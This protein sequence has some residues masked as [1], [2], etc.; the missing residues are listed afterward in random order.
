VLAVL[1]LHVSAMGGCS[2]VDLPAAQPSHRRLL[3]DTNLA[4][5]PEA[6]I[7]VPVA[8][9]A[10]VPSEGSGSFPAS[11]S[12]RGGHHPTP[13]E[14][15]PP[16]AAGSSPHRPSKWLTSMRWLYLTVLP[17]AGLLL[18]AGIACWLLPC[19]KSAVATIGPWKTGLSGQLQKAFVTGVP[20]LQRSELERAC[21][22]FS[23]IIT[24]YPHYT[25]Y[26]GT[27]S[28]GVE[29]AV[30]STMITSSK[31][32]S[33]HSESCFRKKVIGV[34]AH[35]MNIFFVLCTAYQRGNFTFLS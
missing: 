5:R 35:Y 3:Q 9:A 12:P 14:V 25:V 16:A 10:P 31:E 29:I 28:S 26:K 15:A 19:R 18:L 30:V 22:D 7:P 20:N 34:L 21:E 27:L 17:A 13:K 33:E 11:S 1:T 23:N 6:N 2:A 4:A 8:L 32:W 24:S